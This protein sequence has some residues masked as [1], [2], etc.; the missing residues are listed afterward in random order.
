MASR[1]LI[2]VPKSTILYV[3][4]V[5]EQI[6]NRLSNQFGASVIRDICIPSL[7]KCSIFT[8]F[9]GLTSLSMIVSVSKK[10]SL[11]HILVPVDDIQGM[12]LLES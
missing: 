9:E 10:I 4:L 8:I 2:A 7:P 5:P 6:E 1:T 11:E 12:Q 3:G